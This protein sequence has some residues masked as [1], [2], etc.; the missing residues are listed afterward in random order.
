MLARR[1]VR[2]DRVTGT[3]RRSR[4]F[5][6]RPWLLLA[7]T[8]VAYQPVWSAGFIWD[9]DAYVTQNPTLYD[10]N[11]LR[12]IWFEVG[13]TPQYYPLVH[14]VFWIEQHLWGLQPLGYHVVNVL[15]HALAAVLLGVLLGRLRIPGAWLAAFLF[16][17][18]PVN[19]ESVA[20]VTELKNVLSTV[21]Y[22]AAA[23]MY[24]RSADART[25]GRRGDG[26]LWYVAAL[27]CF[28]AALLS[29]TVTCSLPAAV[30]LVCWWQEGR[31][32]R[33]DLV[34][35]APFFAIGALLGLHTSWVE[36]HL[37]GASGPQWSLTFAER[38]LVAGRAVWFYLGTLAW[39]YQL[40]F[41]YPRWE[42][43]A[44]AWW[45]WIFP[46]TLVALGLALWLVRARTG[47]A[48]VATLLFFVGT[49]FP[50]LGFLN[51]YPMRYSFVADHF[52]YLA[53]IGPIALFA[54]GIATGVGDGRARIGA[55]IPAAL[56]GVLAVCT[57][58]QCAT[59][60]NAETLWRVTLARNPGCSMAH[61]NLGNVLLGKGD[62]DE[63][64]AHFERALQLEPDNSEAEESLGTVL[65]QRGQAEQALAHFEH[66]LAV[67]PYAGTHYNVGTALLARGRTN[68]ALEHFNEALRLRPA[69]AEA[70]NNIGNIRFN[71][72]QFQDAIVH[73]QMA[74]SIRPDLAE[75]ANNLG[76]ALLRTGQ[77][78]AAIDA[79]RRALAI[80][81]D[82]AAAVDNVRAVAW[83]L[84][85][86]PD[87]S[88]RD[89][90]RALALAQ[91]VERRIGG[92]DPIVLA[93]LAA[94]YA[95]AGRFADAVTAARRAVQIAAAQGNAA[96][97]DE[98]N[99]ELA[100]YESG[101]PYRRSAPGTA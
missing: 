62:A 21:C 65:L 48:P 88:V 46:A 15:L 67:H 51:V 42:I 10:L 9:D 26:R 75:A 2:A 68:A 47:R 59:Y 1:A 97:I 61:N 85:T 56:V 60:A 27:V 4:S 99:T 25:A 34:A 78:D 83:M 45:Q 93:T 19:V 53:T 77:L 81:P 54:A 70:H 17:A 73:Y 49:L 31:L 40:T 32:R 92:P 11:G 64:L 57:W 29:K 74:L 98:L 101:R 90:T 94:A 30:L 79:Y 84:A 39:P 55:V 82:F 76:S 3:P 37:T 91:D 23:L 5:A 86:A 71:A 18:H 66:A 8:I 33:A 58:R 87:A 35:T 50:A 100:A 14:T 13:A 20:W 6:W 38:V 7:V 72:G 24:L 44:R 12:R 22:L 52:Q 69:Y 16:A 96:L 43:D 89:G 41:I 28:A 36:T 95:E 63:A 80:R